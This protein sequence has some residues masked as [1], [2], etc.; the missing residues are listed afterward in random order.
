MHF[1]AIKTPEQCDL[2]TLHRVRLRLVRQR[3][4]TMNQ[5]RGFLS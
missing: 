3:S 2:L 1:V 5:I 4:A